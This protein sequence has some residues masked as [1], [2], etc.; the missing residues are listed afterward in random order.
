MAI[1]VEQEKKPVNWFNLIVIAVVVVIMFSVVYF[2][3]FNSP[4]LIDVVVPGNL[5]NIKQ[6]SQVQVDPAPVLGALGKYFVGNF[7]TSL[8]IPT[9]GRPNPFLP[10]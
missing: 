8:T 3:F 6:L 7:G 4:E 10:Y 9:P 5:N 1:I 2:I